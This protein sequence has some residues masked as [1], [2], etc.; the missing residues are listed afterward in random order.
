MRLT[1]HILPPCF[2]CGLS[3]DTPLPLCYEC[4]SC[5]QT[6]RHACSRCALPL[7][8]E[9]PKNTL[10]GQC[11]TH[12]PPYTACFAPWQYEPHISYLI[13]HWK[14][15]GA[16]WLSRLLGALWLVQPPDNLAAIDF[17]V[18]IPLHWRR[19]WQRGYNQS[20]LLARSLITQSNEL[21]SKQLRPFALYRRRHTAIQSSLDARARQRNLRHAFASRGHF[22]GEHVALIDDVMTTGCT[23]AQAAT[24]LLENGA[25]HVSVWVI[26]R[27]VLGE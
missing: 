8:R 6:N 23:A 21:H 5:L 20:L 14:Y 16:P 9:H 17:I 2:L 3:S 18:P 22:D 26:A 15:A 12:P 24:A 13:K 27:A 7:A 19:R 1:P 10:C 11:Q 4:K 25:G